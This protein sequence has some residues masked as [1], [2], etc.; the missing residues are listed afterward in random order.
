MRKAQALIALTGSALLLT[1]CGGGGSSGGTS[2]QSPVASF[3]AT[4]TTGQAP[5]AVALDASASRDPDGSITSYGWIFGDSS[6][7]S[8]GPAAS[9]TYQSPGTYTITLNV[10]DDRGTVGSTT[11][12]V[13]VSVG[14][15]PTNVIVSGRITYDRVPF[16]RLSGSGLDYAGTEQRPARGV[17]VELV[18]SDGTIATSTTTDQSGNYSLVA[19]VSTTVFVR[20]KAQWSQQANTV[21]VRNNTNG[22]ALY[23]VEGGSF[24]TGTTNQTRNLHAPSGWASFGGTSYVSPRLAAPFAVL[25]TITRAIE[26]LANAGVADLAAGGIALN[27]Y[28]STL[29]RPSDTFNAST[30]NI[31]TT[32]YRPTDSSG[33]PA[34]IYVL[35]TENNDTDEYDQHI[36]AHEVMHYW[37]DK[38]A[39]S[40]TP[41]GSHSIGEKLDPR[42]AF[43]EG[44]ANAFAGMVLGDPEYR[45]SFGRSQGEDGGFSLEANSYRGIL[46]WQPG[47]F[48]EGSV[49]SASVWP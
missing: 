6:T 15:A 32:L 24:N 17:V 3:T 12:T 48:D 8:G 49:H 20:A 11:R 33:G 14:P 18:R 36:V 42:L 23:A 39:R 35:G 44:F 10:V 34:G 22:N 38:Y 40:D 1:A 2:N 29:N 7:G 37:E 45:D 16:S 28:W 5:L 47:W 46:G 30:G 41:G 27:V 9:H 31:I 4:P 26:F 13:T 25:D 21:S 43:G 19:P